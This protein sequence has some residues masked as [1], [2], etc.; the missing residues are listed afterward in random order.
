MKSLRSARIKKI[1]LIKTTKILTKKLTNNKFTNNPTKDS[2]TFCA[3]I[4]PM[5][6]FFKFPIMTGALLCAKNFAA[7]NS[8][9]KKGATK[10]AAALPKHRKLWFHTAKNNLVVV[11]FMHSL[12][13]DPKLSMSMYHGKAVASKIFQGSYYTFTRQVKAYAE[14][15][16]F[17]TVLG[18]APPPPGPLAV[19]TGCHS[20]S[21]LKKAGI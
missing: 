20:E 11:G 13:K 21:C 1:T 4:R 3:T 15:N 7:V 5:L 2:V 9:T 16:V 8:P 12:A 6:P 19:S 18:A 14:N 17:N 10:K